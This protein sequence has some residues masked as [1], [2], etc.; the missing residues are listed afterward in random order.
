MSITQY[1]IEPLIGV[2]PILLGMTRAE[3]RQHMVAEP[4]SFKKA[5]TLFPNAPEVDAYHDNAFQVFFDEDDRVE[6]IEL[7]KSPNL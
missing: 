5:P 1:S 7:S 4:L 6:Y 2:R 3:S